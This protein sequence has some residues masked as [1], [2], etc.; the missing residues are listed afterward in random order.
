MKL[1]ISYKKRF[2][3]KYTFF[4]NYQHPTDFRPP[5]PIS[6]RFIDHDTNGLLTIKKNYAWD[7]PSGP[8]FDTKNIM[9][10]SLVHDALY[11]LMHDEHIPLEKR[12]VADWLLREIC[13]QDGMSKICADW[14]Y[15][16]VDCFGE[17]SAK[18]DLLQAP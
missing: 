12:E 9:R 8:A 13:F 18:P 16:A 1:I 10:G 3:Y 17:S 6:T 11:Q 7:G 14:V 15:I 4:E 5:H 2:R